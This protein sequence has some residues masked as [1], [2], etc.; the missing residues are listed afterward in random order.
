MLRVLL[1]LVFSAFLQAQNVSSGLSGTIVDTSDAIVPG[2]KIVVRQVRTGFEKS[3][4]SN[5]SGY[6]SFPDLSSGEY[7]LSVQHGGFRKY[8]QTDIALNTGDQRS[9]V[10]QYPRKR[11]KQWSPTG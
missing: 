11:P 8:Q 2:V 5:E 9:L 7:T 4:N 6:F 10:G 3:T 1:L